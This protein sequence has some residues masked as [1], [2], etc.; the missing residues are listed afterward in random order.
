[1]REKWSIALGILTVGITLF[2]LFLAA[3]LYLYVFAM[4]LAL[5][6]IVSA[7][8][9]SKH[10]ILTTT[11]ILNILILALGVMMIVVTVTK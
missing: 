4:V 11:L 7:H 1:M 9:S 2:A 10:W 5:L 8:F 3:T 6:G